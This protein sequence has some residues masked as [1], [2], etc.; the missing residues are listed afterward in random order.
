MD[1]LR[2]Y[3]TRKL[4]MGRILNSWLTTPITMTHNI[5]SLGVL[6]ILLA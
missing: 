6:P 4:L 3:I 5:Y 2:V 1:Y